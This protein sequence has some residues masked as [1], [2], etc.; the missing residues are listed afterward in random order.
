MAIESLKRI[1]K[2]A[3][4]SFWRNGWLSTATVLVMVLTLFVIG[5]LVL[6]SVLFNTILASVEE[7]IDVSVYFLPN[8]PEE[9]IINLKSEFQK[10]PNVREVAYVSQAEALE[11]FRERHKDNPVVIESLQELE[12]NPLEASL[13]ISALDTL[14]FQDIVTAI[15]A[16]Q[17]PTVDKINF[18][19]N[20]LAIERLS[21]ITTASKTTG[22]ALAI[23]LAFVAV[24]VTFN[25][26]R[27]AIYTA[28]DEINVM[29]LV[30]ATAWYIRGPFLVEGIIDGALAAVVTTAIYFPI[31]WFLAPKL[32]LFLDGVNMFDYFV[33]HFFEFFAILLGTSVVLS[34]LSSILAI[35]RYLKV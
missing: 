32:Q 9:L 35:R 31:I 10:I 24:L 4:V 19:E 11:R 8:T 3:A 13:N 25:T 28:R 33:S 23:V 22:A 20:Q 7:K 21:K 12:D 14:K 17:E 15:E 29:R 2:S 27:L 6:S 26:V 18:R 16:R 5:G 34:V 1:M 30:G